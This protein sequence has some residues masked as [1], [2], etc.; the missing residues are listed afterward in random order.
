MKLALTF[1]TLLCFV[2]AYQ[3]P[4]I[5]QKNIEQVLMEYMG[6]C[7]SE[8]GIHEDSLQALNIL[9]ANP[10]FPTIEDLNSYIACL[11][12]KIGLKLHEDGR[13]TKITGP[14]LPIPESKDTVYDDLSIDTDF[15]NEL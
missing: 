10:V 2:S 7:L 9:I 3:F 11:Y 6:P 4:G 14:H 15:D 13:I 12:R 1:T 8:T 5:L